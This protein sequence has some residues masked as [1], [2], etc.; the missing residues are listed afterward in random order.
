MKMTVQYE[1]HLSSG[2]DNYALK[3]GWRIVIY[4]YS[5]SYGAS[6]EILSMMEDVNPIDM[7][8]EAILDFSLGDEEIAED[9]LMKAVKLDSDCLDAWRAL[10]EVRLARQD[11]TGAHAA[12]EKA[13]VIA[14]EDLTAKV[15]LS[16]ILVAKG[17]KEGAEK[18]TAEARILG[19][20]EELKD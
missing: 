2:Q 7:V 11:L 18:A 17:D 12:C 13:L 3:E 4:F 6:T 14:P 5:C 15:S 20:K 10:A 8:E 1:P 9:K 16:R 19:W